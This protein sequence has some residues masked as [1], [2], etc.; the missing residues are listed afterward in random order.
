MLSSLFTN[1]PECLLTAPQVLPQKGIAVTAVKKESLPSGTEVLWGTP[2]STPVFMIKFCE[3][4]GAEGMPPEGMA[5]LQSHAAV[6]WDDGE[7]VRFA[8]LL[9]RGDVAACQDFVRRALETIEKELLPRSAF[10]SGVPRSCPLEKCSP[11]PFTT[12][13]L[14]PSSWVAR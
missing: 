6:R 14:T 7:M 13:T 12:M 5:V 3:A 8:D 9:T 10:I 1:V 2:R 4:Q 11:S